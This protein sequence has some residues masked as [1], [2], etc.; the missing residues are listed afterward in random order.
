[1]APS[2]MSLHSV[3][4]TVSSRHDDTF[5]VNTCMHA[6]NRP[7]TSTSHSP[8]MQ[9][10]QGP[11]SE[12]RAHGTVS[13]KTY[14]SYFRAG[15]NFLFLFVVLVILFAAEVSFDSSANNNCHTCM[16]LIILPVHLCTNQYF[17]CACTSHTI[18]I[19]V[20]LFTL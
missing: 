14:Y 2:L 19:F 9:E 3:V 11:P 12:E 1:M 8:Y 16:C 7:Y 4:D 13:M 5:L 15:G 6:N 10:Q 20:A 17:T 18:M